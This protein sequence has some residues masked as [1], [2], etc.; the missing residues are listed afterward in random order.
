MMPKDIAADRKQKTNPK[1]KKESA[2]LTSSTTSLN[3]SRNRKRL[4][5]ESA[6]KEATILM[7]SE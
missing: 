2:I 5:E 1:I 6:K 7:S 4:R 3:T